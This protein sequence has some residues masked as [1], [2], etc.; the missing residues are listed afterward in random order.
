MEPNINGVEIGQQLGMESAEATITKVEAYCEYEKQR[1]ELTNHAKIVALKAEFSLLL[2]E[3]RE[4]RQR[5][6]HAPP[7]GDL[8]HRKRKA[9]YYWTVAFVLTAAALYFTLYTF[10]PFRMGPKAYLYCLGFAAAVPFLLGFALE[11][12]NGGK[13]VKTITATACVA[14]VVSLVLLAVIRGDLLAQQLVNSNPVVIFDDAQ[15]APPPPETD[16][17]RTTLV[18]LRLVMALLAIAMDFAAGLALHEAWRMASDSSEDR[19]KLETRLAELLGRKVTLAYEVTS[20]QNQPAIFVNRFWSN[21]Y[22]T[23]L[24]HTARS[25]MTK[26]LFIAIALSLLTVGRAMAEPQLNLVIAVDLTRSVAVHAS[27]QPSEFQKNID[28]VTKLL[29]QVPSSSR[30]TI[31]GITDQSFAQ[32]YI[33]LSAEVPDEPGYF[34]ERLTAAKNE[35]VRRWQSRSERLQPSFSHTDILG[36]LLVASQLFFQQV[37]IPDK[38]LIIFSDMRNSTPELNLEASFGLTHFS[39]VLRQRKIPVA[40]LQGIQVYI[41]GVDDAGRS[42]EYWQQLRDS[43]TTYFKDS[44]ADLRG[45]SVL[46]E[47][48]RIERRPSSF[49]GAHQ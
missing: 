20:L 4:L 15:P 14:A 27:G 30:V 7:P 28:A 19:G 38:K 36:A 24:S 29:A 35:L 8:R 25:A 10:E 5:L 44:G 18:L 42:T 34:G 43:W 49:T 9:V 41:L 23:M 31:I 11:K 32:P 22:R 16:F 37:I 6:R 33:S 45:Y 12:W 39:Q 46:R 17:Y 3:E 48:I 40:D 2:D 21:F 47:M 26:L 13:L 1:I